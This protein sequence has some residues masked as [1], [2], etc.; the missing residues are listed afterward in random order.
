MTEPLKGMPSTP[1]SYSGFLTV[2][3][4]TD[5][6]IFFWFFPA[7]VTDKRKNPLFLYRARLANG[8]INFQEVSAA[9][10]PMVIWLQG[11]PGSSSM[12]GLFE[13]HGPISAVQ[14]EDGEVNMGENKQ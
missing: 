12:Y 6:H 13:I 3:Q 11:G 14:G 9:G 2:S 10:A 1:P 4:E 8:K 5:S 7:S